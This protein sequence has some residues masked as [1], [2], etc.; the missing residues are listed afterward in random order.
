VQRSRDF[1]DRPALVQLMEQAQATQ[2]EHEA[3]LLNF[4]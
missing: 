1:R 4:S 2:I 3:M